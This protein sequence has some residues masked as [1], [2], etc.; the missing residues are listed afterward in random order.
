MSTIYIIT[1]TEGTDVFT[2]EPGKINGPTGNF[3]NSDLQLHGSGT[4]TW[5]EDINENFYKLAENFATP[6]KAG[7]PGVPQDENDLGIPGAGINKPIVGQTWYNTTQN[8]LF[9][10]DGTNWN[11][12]D[13]SDVLL[14][15]GS[16]AMTGTLDMGGFKV[17]NAQNP[18]NPQELT[19]KDYVDTAVSGGIGAIA[20]SGVAD[21]ST[22]GLSTV[23]G[24]LDFIDTDLTNLNNT[25]L[26]LSGGTMSGILSMGNFRISNLGTP[27]STNDATTKSYVDG[28]NDKKVKVS[29]NDTTPNFLIDKLTA[30][31]QVTIIENN[32]GGNETVTISVPSTNFNAD[33]VDGW[34]ANTGYNDFTGNRMPIRH[35]SGYLYSNYF[36]MT[37]NDI[38]SN[39]PS[40]VAVETS[41]DGFLRWQTLANFKNVLNVPT[42]QTYT[43]PLI[44]I[45][46][47][48]TGWVHG[49]SSYPDL[50]TLFLVCVSA[51][52]GYSYNDRVVIDPG[53]NFNPSGISLSATTT[54]IYIRRTTTWTLTIAHK[55]SGDGVII[56]ENSWRLLIK[57][58]KIN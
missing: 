21:D 8:K 55:T 24:A 49:L 28:L 2:I 58:I 31:T 39:T 46:G 54:H 17:V 32:N 26:N 34:H 22:F 11:I 23:K 47:T 20:A 35:T 43:S 57:A 53:A 41:N 42:I 27:S 29:S 25:K 19:T 45:S 13:S 1:N 33:M 40:K 6:E 56:N 7:S 16:R 36:N 18:T 51:N 4:T 50:V 44:A 14:L 38:G 10:Y 30:G 5:G 37:A 48:L 3:A 15:D 9:V 52:A 12:P